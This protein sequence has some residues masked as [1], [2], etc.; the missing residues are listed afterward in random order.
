VSDNVETRFETDIY[1]VPSWP[2]YQTA[3]NTEWLYQNLYSYSC[4]PEDKQS[5]S[6]HVEDSNKRSTDEIVRQGGY[7][8]EL[9][10][11]AR[12]EKH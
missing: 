8:P 12:S 1:I 2:A 6:K 9:Y 5:C 7:L 3:T 10:E 11:D 4:P